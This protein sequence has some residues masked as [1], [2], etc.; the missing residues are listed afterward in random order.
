M[1]NPFPRFF[2][3]DMFEDVRFLDIR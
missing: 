3:S 1:Q 2:I